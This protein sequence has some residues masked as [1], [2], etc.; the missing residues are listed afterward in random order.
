MRTLYS[1]L[2]WSVCIDHTNTPCWI[3]AL[4]QFRSPNNHHL[5]GQKKRKIPTVLK[6]LKRHI[7]GRRCDDSQPIRK[8]YFSKMAT[9]PPISQHNVETV[10]TTHNGAFWLVA[11]LPLRKFTKWHW[12]FSCQSGSRTW[13]ISKVVFEVQ[14]WLSQVYQNFFF[15]F[16]EN[17]L[18]DTNSVLIAEKWSYFSNFAN[19]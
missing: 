2:G 5:I 11:G 19:R 17:S 9:R 4:L 6:H 7:M 10:V 8:I 3:L 18:F 12:R 15:F 13:K 14:L 1:E 16:K